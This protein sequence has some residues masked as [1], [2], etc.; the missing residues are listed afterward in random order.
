MMLQCDSDN[1]LS[2]V[3][4]RYELNSS[5]RLGKLRKP[6]VCGFTVQSRICSIETLTDK[7]GCNIGRYRRSRN[8]EIHR[9]PE[10]VLQ[11]RKFSCIKQKWSEQFQKWKFL[12]KTKKIWKRWLAGI[13][14]AHWVVDTLLSSVR[15]SNLVFY[16]FG[17]GAEFPPFFHYIPEKHRFSRC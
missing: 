2:F 13:F 11:S 12:H 6:I 7:R 4:R 3:H 1:A 17:I 8:I 5:F 10:N 16:I 14:G 9:N 15:S